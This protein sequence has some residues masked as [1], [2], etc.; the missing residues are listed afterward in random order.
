MKMVNPDDECNLSTLE[1]EGNILQGL[2]NEYII[3]LLDKSKNPEPLFRT[4][5]A[6]FDNTHK[7]SLNSLDTTE[8]QFAYLVLEFAPKGDLFEVVNI[9]GS[10]TH[11]VARHFFIQ[12]VWGIE[13]LHQKGI[14]HRDIKL[15]NILLDQNYKV[16]IADFGYAT[17]H[18]SD[19]A[20][21]GSKG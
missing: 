1:H 15:E 16:K 11:A 4:P 13:Y 19:T 3:K 17:H 10:L 20:I 5:N 9:N 6:S 7:D 8:S 2:D 21:V 18:H 14:K 12:L